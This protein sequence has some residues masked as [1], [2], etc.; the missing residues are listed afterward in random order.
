M[1][2]PR[3]PATVTIKKTKIV[4]CREI[5]H[6]FEAF[7]EEIVRTINV[8]IN[9]LPPEIS[10][11]IIKNGVIFTG[12]V[13]KIAGLDDFLK[14]TLTYNFTISDDCENVAILGAGKLLNDDALLK[15]VLL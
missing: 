14:R 3:P 11:D 1:I 12:G 13:S 8:T 2:T 5:R 7:L 4:S 15:K 6:V 9:T 10:A